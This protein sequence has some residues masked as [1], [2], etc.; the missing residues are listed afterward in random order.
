MYLSPQ[1]EV[2]QNS[3]QA[4]L[5]KRLRKAVAET[6]RFF[7]RKILVLFKRC[8]KKE[9]C[10]VCNRNVQYMSSS[11]E[12]IKERLTITEVVES[13]IKLDKAGGNLKGKC[14]FHNEKTPSFFVS[15][16]RGSYYCF[17]CGAK[18]DIFTFVQEFEGLDFMG[19]LKTLAL[20]AG[21]ELVRE[22]VQAR[23]ELDRLYGAMEEATSYYQNLLK[24]SAAAKDYL[25]NRGITDTTISEFCIGF[26]PEGWRAIHDHLLKKGFSVAEIE[27]VGLIK[28]TEKGYYDRFRGRIMFPISDSSGRIIA[29]S[30]R[31]LVDDGKSAKYLNSP[32]TVLFNKSNIL[33]GLDKAKL[34]IRKRDYTILVE[35]QMDLIMSHQAG[36]KNTVAVSGTALTDSV[37]SRDDVVN[38]LG[39][40]RRLS[41]NMIIAFDADGAGIRAS[42]RASQVA[43][44]LGMDVKIV[45]IEGGKDPADIILHSI[46]DWKNMLRSAKQVIEF[47]LDTVLARKLDDRKLTKAI[48]EEV[49]PYIVVLQ[50]RMEKAHFVAK[51]RDMTKIDENAIWEDLKRLEKSMQV[52]EGT[53]AGDGVNETSP[54]SRKDSIERK[55]LGIVYWQGSQEKQILDVHV[56]KK[57]LEKIMGK[58]NWDRILADSLEKKPEFIFES[59]VVYKDSEKMAE[60]I[61]EMLKG[62]ETDY[63]KKEFGQVM[64]ALDEAEKK[65]DGAGVTKLLARCQELSNTLAQLSKK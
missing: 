40:V 27:K 15:P 48:S 62:L 55:I 19:A 61:E 29:F 24:E 21:V 20:R 31:I 47:H 2:L 7:S 56:L 63:L 64:K 45:Q 57:R 23:N 13:Y 33:Y 10:N 6:E 41:S 32:D 43:L 8:A 44:S 38:N 4:Y 39:L 5:L 34:D 49:L 12:K 30:G 65:K 16:D 22:N 3:S 28:Q 42:A 18:G 1:V 17:G 46:E 25:K 54:L 14:P 58:E 53:P 52:A 37:V 51:I 9:I 50:S 59:E 36:I 60:E 26:V 35:G 11:V